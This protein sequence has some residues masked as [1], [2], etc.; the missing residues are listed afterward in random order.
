MSAD[1]WVSEPVPMFTGAPVVDAFPRL[2]AIHP[3]RV[4]RRSDDPRPARRAPDLTLPEG[5]DFGGQ[6]CSVGA[7][8]TETETAGLVVYRDGALVHERYDLGMTATTAW[9]AWSVT[10]SFVAALVGIAIGAGAIRSVRDPVAVYAPSLAGSAYD[11]AT[12]EDVLQMSSGARWSENYADPRS[13]VRRLAR[14]RAAGGSLDAFAATLAR[15]HAPGVVNRYNSMDTHVLSMVVRVATG[16]PLTAYL[17]EA[18]WDPLG[19]EDDAFWI[20]DGQGVEWAGAGLLTTLRDRAKLGLA[21]LAQGGGAIPADW[22]RQ[23]TRPGAERLA[24]GRLA[25][26][27]PF[28]Y[29]Y[30]WWLA[31]EAGAYAAIGVYNQY[32]YVDPARRVV[33]AKASAN[34]RYGR[35]YDE[36]GYRDAEHMAMFRA[37]AAA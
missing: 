9:P 29:G 36:A 32:V 7:F 2:A 37:I 27:Y 10:K 18:L 4:V 11:G 20:V 28:G 16:R 5:Y 34:R 15:E 6:G 13:E 8:L 3:C 31:D 22:V 25:P 14:A 30:H 35:T 17:R 33:I 12:I 21:F 23:S 19:M 26:G 1:T 24:P